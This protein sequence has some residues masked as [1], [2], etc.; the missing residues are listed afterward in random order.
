MQ[1]GRLG[2]N[3]QELPAALAGDLER[4]F[5]DLVEAYQDR[6]YAFA[7]RLT[8]VPQDAEEIIVDAFVR[9]YRALGEYDG[10][11]IRGLALKAW[12]Y[13]IT[14]NVVRN[15]LRGRRLSLVSI[16]GAD[17][18]PALSLPDETAIGPDVQLE[19]AQLRQALADRV[20][21]LPERERIAVVLRHIQGYSYAE[22]ATFLEQP[23]GTVK[24]NVHRGVR[25]LREA[26]QTHEEWR[27]YYA[28]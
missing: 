18:E 2:V 21:D 4:H 28:S 24:A 7:L 20:A 3:D 10:E 16:E 26:L 27:S 25:R 13:Q 8:G 9:A 5:T 11:R 17:D 12:L 6:L 23:V 14:L 15:R 1:R 19:Q 22:I